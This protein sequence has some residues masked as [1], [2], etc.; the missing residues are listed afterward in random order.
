M[1]LLL[2]LLQMLMN[3]VIATEDANTSVSTHRAPTSVSATRDIHCDPTDVPANEVIIFVLFHHGRAPIYCLSLSLCLEWYNGS[4]TTRVHSG[5][6]K[7]I[8][9]RLH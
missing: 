1:R 5:M 2:I 7:R 9:C 8:Q 3:V 4:I 6:T